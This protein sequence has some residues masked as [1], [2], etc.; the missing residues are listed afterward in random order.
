M[1]PIISVRSSWFIELFRSS[2]SLF[3]VLYFCM[4]LKWNIEDSSY[5][6]RTF[7]PFNSVSFCI[8]YFVDVTGY[9]NIIVVFSYCQFSDSVMSD[10]LQPHGLQHAR[11]PCPSPTPELPQTHIHCIRVFSGSQF[12]ASGGQSIGV[13]ASASVLPMNTQD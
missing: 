10:S 5:Y 6:H 9:V 8:M 11:L 4:L 1:F 2:L 3:L 13:A 7:S 12:F